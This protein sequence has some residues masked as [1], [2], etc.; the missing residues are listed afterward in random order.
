MC[1]ICGKLNFDHDNQ[2]SESLLKAKGRTIKNSILAVQGNPLAQAWKVKT[3]TRQYRVGRTR[4]GH[5]FIAR[6]G[7]LAQ[8]I[9]EQSR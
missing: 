5:F 1:G 4:Q 8:E 6:V 9:F 7:T 3:L 2:D